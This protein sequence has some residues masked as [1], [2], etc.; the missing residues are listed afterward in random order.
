MPGPLPFWAREQLKLRKT[1]EDWVSWEIDKY[2][3]EG[4]QK[5]FGDKGG[6]GLDEAGGYTRAFVSGYCLSGNERI[7]AFMKQFRDDWHAAVNKAGHFWHGYDSNE[8]GDYIT[9]TAEA[10]TQFL[11]NVLYLDIGDETTVAM[12]ED[13]A[14]HLGNWNDEVQDWY[15]W[16][17]HVFLS[18]FLGTKSPYHKPPYNWQSSRHFRV[19]VIASAAYEATGNERYLNLCRDYCDRWVDHLSGADIDASNFMRIN[20]ISDDE[21]RRY[22]AEEPYKDDRF[23][24]GRYYNDILQSEPKP[25]SVDKWKAKY[26]VG[27][28][29]G[30]HD[31]VMTWL[32]IYRYAREERYAQALR[33][34]MAMWIG[35]GADGP[36]QITGVE[37][38][39]GVHLPKYR[40]VVKDTSLDE[41]YLA[42]WPDGVTSYLLTGDI[43]RIEG[44][45]SIAWGL[46]G[47]SLM[48][49]CGVWGDQF[50]TDHACN[51][52]SIAGS[53]S[54]YVMPALFMPALG[55]LGV[56]YGRAP[57]INVLYYTRGRIGLPPDVAALYVPCKNGSPA[58]QLANS[59]DSARTIAVRR[60]DPLETSR[61]VLTAPAPEG[62]KEVTIGPGEVAEA[63]PG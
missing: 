26:R 50:A 3:E 8:H 60:I 20:L 36:T 34:V 44:S 14:E 18:Y 9:H 16:D 19:L 52:L 40:D 56:H 62:L 24:F 30:P 33:R 37:P 15:D 58:V 51:A 41:S 63:V 47:Q 29:H 57:W 45:A 12:V 55:G 21:V 49:N 5:L 61:L 54:A 6:H 28:M 59:G 1:F 53:S 39:C 31:P 4:F 10:F 42:T 32:D 23:H 13:A 43:A 38:H 7:A 2:E 17:N 46:F 11:L 22:A 48:R 35:H 25:E 27:G